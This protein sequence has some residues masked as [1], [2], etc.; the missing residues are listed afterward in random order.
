MLMLIV[1]TIVSL[2]AKAGN[3]HK[4]IAIIDPRSPASNLKTVMVK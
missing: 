3:L 4:L 2:P 1:R